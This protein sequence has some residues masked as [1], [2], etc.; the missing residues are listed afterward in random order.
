MRQFKTASQRQEYIDAYKTS[1]ESVSQWSERNGLHRTTVYRWL[2]Q[3]ANNN[4]V[5][6]K[7]T[8]RRP[9]VPANEPAQIN[10]LPVTKVNDGERTGS[11]GPG[12][13]RAIAG[14]EAPANEEIRVQIGG[15]T[16]IAPDG[17]KRDT[18]ETVFRALQSIC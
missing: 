11:K 3:D 10:W 5:K 2:R 16:V 18:L 15:F 4:V 9:G 6:A 8:L 13:N 12:T 1:G 14:A 7:T 17:F